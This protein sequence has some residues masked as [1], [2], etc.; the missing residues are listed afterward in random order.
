ML[1]PVIT[2]V[3]I[4]RGEQ[5]RH[6]FHWAALQLPSRMVMVMLIFGLSSLTHVIL[7]GV[8]SGNDEVDDAPSLH[9]Q[10]A[11][12]KDVIPTNQIENLIS[13]LS[14]KMVKIFK[15]L[16]LFLSLKNV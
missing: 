10:G 9:G 1:L 8:T 2:M 15:K 6:N 5:R 14:L 11:L 13:K 4:G 16:L 3:D 7:F 12:E